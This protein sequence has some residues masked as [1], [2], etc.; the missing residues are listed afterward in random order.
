MRSYVSESF[1]KVTLIKNKLFLKSEESL[2]LSLYL[3][4]W[5]QSEEPSRSLQLYFPFRM[6]KTTRKNIK[7]SS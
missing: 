7:L 3:V 4:E 6:K 5:T 1:I 2:N